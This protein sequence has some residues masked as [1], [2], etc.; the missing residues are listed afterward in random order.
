M[1]FTLRITH[2]C[3]SPEQ[4][5][6]D[7]ALIEGAGKTATASASFDFILDSEDQ[8]A[9]RWYWEDYLE[10]AVESASD[11][12]R[13]IEGKL[14]AVGQQLFQF[15]FP[16]GAAQDLWRKFQPQLSVGRVEIIT[17]AGD[18]SLLPWELLRD[19]ATQ[20]TLATAPYSFVRKPAG[21]A[22]EAG[23]LVAGTAPLRV[24]TA[25]CRP[26][27]PRA[28]PFRSPAARL[29]KALRAQMRETVR[30]E[31]LRPSTFGQLGSVLLEAE[32]VGEPFHVLHID[33]YGVYGDVEFDGTPEEILEVFEQ[34]QLTSVL[35]GPHGYLVFD[36]ATLD[37]NVQLV[38]GAS[39]GDLMREAKVPVLTLNLCRVARNDFRAEPD[40]MASS[41]EGTLR[42][43][44]SLCHDVLEK[45]VRAAVNLPYSVDP[46]KAAEIFASLYSDLA[47]GI[48]VGAAVTRQ[49]RTLSELAD[50]QISYGPVRLED[51]ATPVSYELEPLAAVRPGAGQSGLSALQVKEA[52]S[53]TALPDSSQTP[54]DLPLPSAGP[55]FGRDE[56]VLAIDRTFRNRSVVLLEAEAGMGKTATAGQF[57]EWYT[58]TEGFNGPVLFTSFAN[59]K[60]LA[61]VLDQLAVVFQEALK[62]ADYSRITLPP[63]ERLEV[64][65]HVL[66]QI[67][68]L[69][70]WDNVEQVAGFPQ[71]QSSSWTVE[72]QEELANFLRLARESQAKFLLLSRPVK[73]HWLGDLHATVELPPLPIRERL[74]LARSLAERDGYT[75]GDVD[76][77][78]PILEFSQGNPL[79]IQGLAQ[80]TLRQ[81]LES[82]AQVRNF[83]EQLKSGAA[84]FGGDG[85]LGVPPHLAATI[86]HV[87]GRSFG[88]P[89]QSIIALL[90]LFDRAVSVPCLA[91]TFGQEGSGHLPEVAKLKEF[92]ELKDDPEF[93]LLGRVA[94]FGFLA[95]EGTDRYTIHEAFRWFLEKRFAEHYPDRSEPESGR[96]LLSVFGRSKPEEPSRQSLAVRS[97]IEELGRLGRR[98]A[99]RA[100]QGDLEAA[101]ELAAEESNLLQAIELARQLAWWEMIAG[102]V[103]G[104][105]ALY[106]NA[107]RIAEWEYR[108]DGLRSDCVE[109]PSQGALPGREEF[110]RAVTEQGVRIARLRRKLPRAE[111]LQ[112]LCLNWDREQVAPYLEL[113]SEDLSPAQRATLEKFAQSLYRLGEILRIQGF[114]ESKVEEEAIAIRERLGER[115]SASEW[116]FSLGSCYR[117]DQTVRDLTKAERWLRHSLDLKEEEDNPGRAVCLRGL[118]QV[119]WE[120]FAEARKTNRPQEELFRHLHDARALY[121][122]AIDHEPSENWAALAQ[123]NQQLGHICFSLGNLDRA[124]PYYRESIRHH[125]LHENREAVAEI[126]FSLAMALR[127]ANRLAEARRYAREAHNDFQ[128]LSSADPEMVSRAGQLVNS[129]EQKLNAKK[130]ARTG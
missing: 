77:W 95:Q 68:V 58:L 101:G 6:V 24:L 113:P 82:S 75:L 126:R 124:L 2:S 80:Q 62:K 64:A 56:T 91:D 76:D 21:V 107:D 36:S 31:F 83:V 87:M 88:K 127:D 70:V 122:R 118:A 74:Q 130:P 119:A 67:S 108:I 105:G 22:P 5:K 38:D 44:H 49:R 18:G 1:G 89:E 79:A 4:H 86:D 120:R 114:P 39:L 30:L 71:G 63:E 19:T 41:P 85:A 33:A 61:A 23:R 46:L 110:R 13:E 28:T 117:D 96:K 37:N 51:W 3:V 123:H 72:E 128:K 104:L 73:S 55:L 81:G 45:G 100:E 94:A 102:C 115:E 14:A 34:P 15:T 103:E 92:Q 25:I 116:A 7:L 112:R 40:D 50:R 27:S 84:S 17:Q 9:L 111:E 125:E 26:P 97:F 57:A 43:F 16:S 32:A 65:L 8:E 98:A 10:Y 53:Q 12:A 48:E 99:Q 78:K 90:H 42:A 121:M 20:R 69:W 47:R 109:M 129:I 29:V 54:N 106:E 35:K 66:N 52:L 93:S 11:I 60:T 59:H